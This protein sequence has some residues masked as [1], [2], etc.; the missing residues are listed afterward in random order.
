MAQQYGTT[1]DVTADDRLWSLLA[2]IFSPIIPIIILFM[3]DKK[4]R[5][6]IKYNAFQA[7]AWGIVIYVISAVL[8]FIVIGFCL[9]V[10]GLVLNIYWGIQ[11]YNGKYVVIP[12]LTDFIKGQGWI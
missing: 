10:I 9:G 11:A 5:P 6:F 1:T 12:V 8:S 2:W 7:L 3:E 4:N